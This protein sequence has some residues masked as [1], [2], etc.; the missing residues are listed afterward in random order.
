MTARWLSTEDQVVWRNY[1]RATMEINDALDRELIDAHGLS[2]NE[3]EVMVVLSE[4]EDHTIRMS[5]LAEQLVNSRSR[6]THTVRRMEQRGLVK[7]SACTHDGRGV[8]CTLTAEGYEVLK[9]AA[10]SHVESVRRTIF[11]RLT[12]EEIRQ[13]GAILAKLGDS[14]PAGEPA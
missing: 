6:L 4:Q 5:H 1:L 10:P 13:F 7:R 11:D 2:L 14:A 12:P 9:Q 3:Y 8:N